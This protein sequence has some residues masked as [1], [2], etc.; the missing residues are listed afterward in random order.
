[1][2]TVAFDP[3]LDDDARR[4]AVFRGEISVSAPTETTIAF[5]AFAREL[6][7]EA[8]GSLDPEVAQDHMSVE[9]YAAI[10]AELKPRFIHHPRSK[11]FI[12]DIIRER[13]G[14]LELT[15]FDVPRLRSSTSGGY[16]Y[17]WN[18]LRLAPPP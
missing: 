6:V 3:N 18:R 9:E 8:F 12:R 1:M 13:G 11:V 7:E 16:P 14:D 15:Y 5:C 17:D 4:A 2:A 10:L